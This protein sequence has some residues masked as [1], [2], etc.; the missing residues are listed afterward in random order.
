MRQTHREIWWACGR[1][2]RYPTKAKENKVARKQGLRLRV[3]VCP[4]CGSYHLT[5]L[6]KG[7]ENDTSK[8]ATTA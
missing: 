2:R 1:K 3:Y 5:K 7:K 4:I 8:E 6:R